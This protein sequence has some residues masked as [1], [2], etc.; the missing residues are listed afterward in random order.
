MEIQAV[1]FPKGT[2]VDD[3]YDW[4]AS[5]DLRPLKQPRETKNFVRFRIRDPKEFK[6]FYTQKTYDQKRGMIELVVGFTYF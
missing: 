4:L 6:H 3:M 1:L 5:H 2:W